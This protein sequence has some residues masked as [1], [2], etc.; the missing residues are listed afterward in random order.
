MSKTVTILKLE[1]YDGQRSEWT[2]MYF[3]TEDG[4]VEWLE[5]N[6]YEIDDIHG[7]KKDYF[8][9]ARIEHEELH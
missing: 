3:R 2:N 8:E 1:K 7:W 9:T 5:K 6:G 4:A